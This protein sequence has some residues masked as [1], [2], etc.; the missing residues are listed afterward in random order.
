MKT[1]PNHILSKINIFCKSILLLIV[2]LI[3]LSSSCKKNEVGELSKGSLELLP[4]DTGGIQTPVYYDSVIEYGY[5]VYKPSGYDQNSYNY[6]LLVFLHGS[7]EKGNSYNDSANLEK[8]LIHGPPKLIKEKRWNPRYP[9]IVISPQCHDSWW[10]ANKLHRFFKYLSTTYRT[11]TTRI[12]LTGLSM[13]GFGTY[14]YVETFADKG[15]VAAVVPI[16]GGGKPSKASKYMNMPLW[17]FHGEADSTVKVTK[18]K[19]MVEA[20]NNLSPAIK[21]KLTIFPG[22]GHNSWTKTYDGT[23][24]GTGSMEYDAFSESIYDWLFRYTKY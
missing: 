22:V 2:L 24:M 15:Y 10:D 21:A 8:I 3:T 6:P 4:Q 16:C 5:Y 17:A 1:H 19:E 14:G 12:Y 9:M 23:G 18:S 13:G 20:I 7:G 11:D